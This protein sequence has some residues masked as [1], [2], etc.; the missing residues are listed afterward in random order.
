M[1]G[2]LGPEIRMLFYALTLKSKPHLSKYVQSV[3]Y[4]QS[5]YSIDRLIGSTTGRL[6]YKLC[7]TL[8]PISQNM[9]N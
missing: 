7:L 8:N 4:K 6:F 1:N 9:F 3:F 2:L 5:A